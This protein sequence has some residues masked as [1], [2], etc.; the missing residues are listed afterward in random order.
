MLHEQPDSRDGITSSEYLLELGRSGVRVLSGEGNTLWVRR[1]GIGMQRLPVLCTTRPT[2]YELVR[3]FLRGPA[4]V[5]SY[6]VEPHDSQ[7]ANGWS[8]I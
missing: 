7:P 1:E 8:Y 2:K 3:A 5:V 4:A 6:L